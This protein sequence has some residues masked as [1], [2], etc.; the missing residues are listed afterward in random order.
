MRARRRSLRSISC[1]TPLLPRNENRTPLALE[2]HVRVAQRRQAVRAIRSR[3]LVVADANQR[4]LEQPDDRCEHL[5]AR[6]A[7]AAHVLGGPAA[8][9]RQRL[10]EPDHAVV[11]RFVAHFPPLR[12]IAILLAPARVAPRGLQVPARIGTDP[13]AGPRRRD[14]QRGDPREVR[15]RA[16]GASVRVRVSEA[17]AATVTADA[18][19]GVG[20]VSETSGL[21]RADRIEHRRRHCGCSGRGHAKAAR[22]AVLGCARVFDPRECIAP[23]A[24]QPGFFLPGSVVSSKRCASGSPINNPIA[25]TSADGGSGGPSSSRLRAP[26][27]NLTISAPAGSRAPSQ[28]ASWI[29]SIPRRRVD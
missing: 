25:A 27:F 10:R 16:D 19:L 15:P 3:V 29:H 8:D 22:R 14:D 13:D 20:R 21:R 9:G 7:L 4:L 11:F 28:A 24:I 5:L 23:H 17:P 1:S 26:T 12:V 18:R 2:F 6:Q